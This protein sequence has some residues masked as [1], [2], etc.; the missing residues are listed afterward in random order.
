MRNLTARQAYL[1]LQRL[2]RESE[3]GN[4]QQLLELYLHERFLARLAVSQYRERFVLKGGMLLASF[5]LR[6]PTRDADILALH[7][8]VNEIEA[9]V[10]EIAS[11]E[12]ADG[13]TFS[14]DAIA[15]EVIR[16]DGDYPGLR[17]T[18][19]AG[20]DRARLRLSVD[21]NFGDPVN[22]EQIE[23]PALLDD[24]VGFSVIR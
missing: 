6:R 14:S 7:V 21:V 13:V 2:A 23:V 20:L 11:I 9:V 12:L 22:P 10:A 5:E 3:R 24:D 18:I 1:E 16:Q 17:I 15:R 8:P 4:T 19:P